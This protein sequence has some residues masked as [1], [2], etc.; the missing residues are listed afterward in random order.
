MKRL[1]TAALGI[2]PRY[3]VAVPERWIVKS[4]AGKISR[5]DTRTR[6]TTEFLRRKAFHA[7]LC[8]LIESFLE[9]VEL[10]NRVAL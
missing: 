5:Q 4:T 9:S 1:I 10:A 7:M 6:F 8:P 3:A 2:P